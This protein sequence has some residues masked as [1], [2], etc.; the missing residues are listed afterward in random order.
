MP[1]TQAGGDC[2][3]PSV[4]ADVLCLHADDANNAD[5]DRVIILWYA[6][7]NLHELYVLARRCA[8]ISHTPQDVSL[9]VAGLSW[10]GAMAS[11]V[12]LTSRL[13]VACMVGLGSDSPRVMYVG[14]F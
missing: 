6:G 3:Q 8:S 2:Q 11:C 10:G 12:A 14:L 9:G 5:A 4:H 1:R 7:T 13:P